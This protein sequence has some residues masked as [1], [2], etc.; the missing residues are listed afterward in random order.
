[1][2]GGA[3][4]HIKMRYVHDKILSQKVDLL[5]KMVY[6]LYM[7]LAGSYQYDENLANAMCEA[8]NASYSDKASLHE[9]HKVYA[10]VLGN[11]EINN[12]LEIGLFLNNLQHTDLTAWAA[13]YPEANIYGG[14]VKTSQLFDRDNIKMQYLDQSD[15]ASF[16]TFK[17][18]F[19]VEFDVILDDAS[20][21]YESTINTFVN[22][23][24]VLK[25]GGVYIIEDC[26][27]DHPDNNDWQ[28][29]VSALTEYFNENGYSYEVFQ[30]RSPE[31]K[32]DVETGEPTEEDAAHDDYI[33][34][35]YKP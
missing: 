30:S 22:L 18:T 10:H 29:T 8:L 32:Q 26:Q 6:Y 23:F 21:I 34:C 17:Q 16:T 9:Y 31:K 27:S 15:S 35:V 5:C 24:P 19:P 28:Q 4:N 12:F 14:D 20:H 3:N 33:V 2:T 7:K 11:I 25:S 1:M 13:L